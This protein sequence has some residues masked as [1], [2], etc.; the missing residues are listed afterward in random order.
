[1]AVTVAT[2]IGGSGDLFQFCRALTGQSDAETSDVLSYLR[3]DDAV[4]L[5]AL[6]GT[7]ALMPPSEQA[8]VL[9]RLLRQ[10]RDAGM[11]AIE[12]VGQAT[13]VTAVVESAAPAAVEAPCFIVD[14]ADLNYVRSMT[15]SESQP[16]GLR[17]TKATNV[18]DAAKDGMKRQHFEAAGH[19]FT[20][21]VPLG[22]AAQQPQWAYY[23][24]N[25]SE[26]LQLIDGEVVSTAEGIND[27]SK[28]RKRG[29]AKEV[30]KQKI[31][32]RARSNRLGLPRLA[33]RSQ[34]RPPDPIAS[35]SIS[36]A[37][38]YRA[39][40]WLSFSP[41]ASLTVRAC[42]STHAVDRLAAPTLSASYVSTAGPL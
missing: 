26:M 33:C 41:S 20:F 42:S 1:M 29:R 27:T 14:E 6:R 8:Q 9:S 7:L 4:T 35:A 21:T 40:S 38:R 16:D 18:A 11:G 19:T 39:P 31:K 37:S 24:E 28:A 13:Q 36:R 30:R 15:E 3:E 25:Q 5:Q 22:D 23:L 17:Q 34:F 32:V 10:L 2:E 12:P